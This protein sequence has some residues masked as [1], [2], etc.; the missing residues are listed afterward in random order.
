MTRYFPIL[1]VGLLLPATADAQLTVSPVTIEFTDMSESSRVMLLRVGNGRGEAQSVE[2]TWN[3]FDQDID[4]QHTILPFG[5]HPNSCSGRVSAQ[6]S[7]FLIEARSSATVRIV[8]EP[9]AE[10]CHSIAFVQGNALQTVVGPRINHR[11]GVK[12]YATA[13]SHAAEGRIT[14]LRFE[15][16]KVELTVENTGARILRARGRIEIWSAEG[17]RVANLDIRD[18][19]VLPSNERRRPFDL[20][21]PLPAG[22]YTAIAVIDYGG[23]ARIGRRATFVVR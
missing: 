16:G 6:P 11:T 21:T 1:L 8:M 4:G 19:S 3:D 22:E 13:A 9:G 23:A 20:E 14:G 7:S 2:V 17:Q 15:D 12:V 10:A 18:W 5:T